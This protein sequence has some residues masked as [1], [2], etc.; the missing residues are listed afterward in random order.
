MAEPEN[1]EDR[2]NNARDPFP[3]TRNSIIVGATEKSNEA[4]TRLL[5]AYREPIR[6][7]LRRQLGRVSED[8]VHDFFCYIRTQD[9]FLREFKTV[10]T[11][12]T[13]RKYIQRWARNWARTSRRDGKIQSAGEDDLNLLEIPTEDNQVDEADERQWEQ[14]LLRSI[15][16]G[17]SKDCTQAQAENLQ[18]VLRR[19]GLL[20]GR[21]MTPKEL[22]KATG[23]SESAVS[24]AIHRTMNQLKRRLGLTAQITSRHALDTHEGVSSLVARASELNPDFGADLDAATPETD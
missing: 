12:R 4:W 11:P 1:K 7:V 18:L 10:G 15:I 23:R 14:A 5:E 22:A 21:E 9:K 20:G 8:D 24:V 16:D 6:I 2:S 19:Y 13:F 17:F 3:A